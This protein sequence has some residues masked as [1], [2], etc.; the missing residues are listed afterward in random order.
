MAQKPR[1]PRPKPRRGRGGTVA[2]SIT[3]N[4][5]F[6]NKL[7]RIAETMGAAQRP[8]PLS[9][10]PLSATIQELIRTATG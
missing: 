10:L 5:P 9:R 8:V 7:V 3:L 2:V 1:G 6:Y 4:T